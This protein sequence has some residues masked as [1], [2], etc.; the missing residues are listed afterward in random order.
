MFKFTQKGLKV[1]FSAKNAATEIQER[2]LPGWGTISIPGLQVL[3][4]LPDG[5]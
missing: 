1:L 2:E 4:N 3:L 5:V